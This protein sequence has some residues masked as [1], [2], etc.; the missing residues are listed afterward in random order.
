MI[1]REFELE[2]LDECVD[3]SIRAYSGEP[4][5]Q[6]DDEH[7]RYASGV[8]LQNFYANSHF[9][10]FVA[11]LDGR[12]VG[13]SVGFL[14]PYGADMNYFVDNFVICPDHQRQGV[15]SR[16]VALMKDELSKIGVTAMVLGTQRGYPAHRFYESLGF[17]IFGDPITLVLEF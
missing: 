5:N 6:V 12:I 2:M 17:K 8:Y 3:L 16:F 14:K 11:Y 7:T 1:L 15:G 9:R 13:L 10:G 4:W